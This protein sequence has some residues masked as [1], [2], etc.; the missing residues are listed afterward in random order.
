MDSISALPQE[1]LCVVFYLLDVD[2]LKNLC[3]VCKRFFRLLSNDLF[4]KPKFQSEYKLYRLDTNNFRTWREQYCYFNQVRWDENNSNYKK[5]ISLSNNERTAS[6]VGKLK[7]M[8][9]ACIRSLRKFVRGEYSV[10]FR[11][12]RK[13]GIFG[14]GISD[15][16]FDFKTHKY[17][18]GYL[19]NTD[20]ILYWTSGQFFEFY[21]MYARNPVKVAELKEG[22][23]LGI[24]INMDKKTVTFF[25]NGEKQEKYVLSSPTK[26]IWLAANLF[27]I[28][29]QVTLL[30]CETDK[31]SKG[32]VEPFA[33]TDQS[34][35]EKLQWLESMGMENDEENRRLLE[36]Y[37]GDVTK[38][39]KDYSS[40]AI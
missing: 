27:A 38:V 31:Y 15:K 10:E 26:E 8:N 37:N 36:K 12:D 3:Y 35:E 11:I 9:Y 39:I 17:S 4:W 29:D 25:K 5:G 19:F 7:P 20:H 21:G 28:G 13:V 40:N 2:D 24:L 1:V 34:F 32:F 30:P 23:V 22:D 6:V 16:L 33:T 18:D 14:I